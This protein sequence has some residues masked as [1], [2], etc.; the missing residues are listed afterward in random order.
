MNG[1]RS[2]PDVL[3]HVVRADDDLR[4]ALEHGAEGL[5][6]GPRIRRAGRVA[7]A[8][9]DEEPRARRDRGLE[10]G[11]RDLESTVDAGKY[12]DGRAVGD[13]HHVGVGHPVRRRDDGLVAGVE[14][15]T[16]QVEDGL[17]GAARH[18]DLRARVLESVV[19]AELGDDRVLELVRALDCRVARV[20]AA[21]RGD[22]GVLD[23]HG[24]VEVRLAGAEA[25]DVLALG[26]EARGAAGDGERRRR[27]DALDALCESDGHGEYRLALNSAKVREGILRCNSGQ[28]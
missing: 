26:L 25:D 21:D 24:R 8:V 10:L 15:G 16:A 17:L 18:E 12:R 27:L 20:T 9:Q 1:F 14:Q 19:A 7:R 5:E 3:V 22:A 4:V 23:V 11:R 28:A 13:Q 2:P 6:L